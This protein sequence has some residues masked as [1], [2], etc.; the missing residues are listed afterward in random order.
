MIGLFFEVMPRLGHEQAYF[1][2]AADLRPELDKNPGLL[3]IDRFKNVDRPRIVLSHSHWRDEA[4]LAGWRTHAKHHAAQIAARKQH[5]EDYRLRIGQL[6]CEWTPQAGAPRQFEATN[7]Y[8]D[9][10]LRQER[11]M[12]V[13]TANSPVKAAAES[14][15]LASISR[16]REYIVLAMAPTL[17]D[18]LR[19]VEQLSLTD[20]MTSIRLYLVSR[21]YG[22]FDRKE[23][24]QYYPPITRGH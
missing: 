2:V 13:S 14:D 6:V 4:S 16:E 12:V 17:P 5:F 1:D 9:P 20:A 18:G 23:A 24:P 11:F 22:M 7:S 21:D 10:G 19:A 15:I 8:N 3:F